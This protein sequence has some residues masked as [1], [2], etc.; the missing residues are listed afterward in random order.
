MVPEPRSH[1]AR[2]IRLLSHGL[3]VGRPFPPPPH[4][5]RPPIIIILALTLNRVPDVRLKIIPNHLVYARVRELYDEHPRI[6]MED[7]DEL[8]VL[9]VIEKGK[10]ARVGHVVSCTKLYERVR[11]VNSVKDHGQ[12]HTSSTSTVYSSISCAAV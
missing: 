7:V 2:A 4:V 10:P 11:L 3:I 5:G 6:Q 8:R 1:V 9:K 12:F